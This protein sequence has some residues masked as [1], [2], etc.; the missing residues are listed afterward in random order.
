ML[1]I[2]FI[3]SASSETASMSY[4]PVIQSDAVLRRKCDPTRSQYAGT[5]TVTITVRMGGAGRSGDALRI[6]S[7]VSL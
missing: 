6:V 3:C 1:F 5:Y 7:R 4:R 2:A